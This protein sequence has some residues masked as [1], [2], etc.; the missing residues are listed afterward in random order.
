MTKC[1]ETWLPL[2]SLCNCE[3][4]LPAINNVFYWLIFFRNN[5]VVI[6]RRRGCIDVNWGRW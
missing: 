3:V 5:L 2:F 1:A 6:W 4:H